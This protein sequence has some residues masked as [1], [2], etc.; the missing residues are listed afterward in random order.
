MRHLFLSPH[1]DDAALS[2]GGTIAR[3][4]S[5]GEPVVVVTIFGG[6]PDYTRLS[7]FA[8]AIHA[9][10]QAGEDPIDVRR[11]E[12]RLALSILEAEPLLLDFLDCIY[13]QDGSQERWLYA[14]E[15]AI[16]GSV[17]AVDAGLV[18]ELAQAFAALASEPEACRFY[19]PLA[20]GNHVDHQVTLSA[21][22][23]LRQSHHDVWFY[24]DYPYVVRDSDGLARALA[25]W[26]DPGRWLAKVVELSGRDL[27]VKTAA[28]RAYRS[29]LGVLFASS[30]DD[31]VGMA[32]ADFG[33]RVARSAGVSGLAERFWL[34]S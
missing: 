9:R 30:G 24:E 8:Q 1:Y 10:P 25:R 33:D 13:R 28:V 4:G 6:K 11:A 5:E 23:R 19:A 34:H 18:E 22:L 15:Q 27:E 26:R 14:G 32:L 16:F 29:Q 31:G 12:E 7:P 3:L 17:D 21:A 20:I 2:C